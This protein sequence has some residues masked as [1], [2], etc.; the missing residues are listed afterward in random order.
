MN[1]WQKLPKPIIGLSPMDGVTDY[2]YRKIINKYGKKCDLSFTEFVHV[3]S[4]FK[5]RVKVYKDLVFDQSNKPTI[6]QLFGVD[7]EYF[8]QSAIIICQL[9][10]DGIDIN[11][12]CPAKSVVK[13]EGGAALIKNPKLAQK[14]IKATKEGVG[15]WQNGK[16]I[17]DLDLDQEK[18]DYIK[19][20]TSSSVIASLHD[21]EIIKRRG[22]LQKKRKSIPVSVKTR[23]G[24]NKNTI[25]DWIKYLIEANPDAI[26]VHGRTFSQLYS[27][28]A[29]WDSIT[30]VS[31]LVKNQN[32]IYLGNGDVKN[33][34]DGLE[35][36]KKYNTDGALIGRHAFG[37]PWVFTDKIPSPQ[38]KMKVM[39]EH[40][41]YFND[42]YEGKF[43]YA[44][45]KHLAWY[46]KGFAGAKDLRIKLMQIDTLSQLNEF[47]TKT[48]PVNFLN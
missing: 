34:Q 23:L 48:F 25:S 47:L 43:F 28:Q 45:R 9:G 2:P 37:N 12:G 22:N 16:T 21:F 40:A 8:R 19:N 26:T 35:K 30:S 3:K 46:C 4:L 32:I 31:S 6:A 11:M 29:D 42:F 10:F 41:K 18:K 36:T 7:P 14:I 1:F 33:Y 5:G 44:F 17:D 13:R 27:G 24:F 38:D 15:D 39:L 20:F